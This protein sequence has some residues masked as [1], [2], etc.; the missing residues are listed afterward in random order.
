MVWFEKNI[1]NLKN[2][3]QKLGVRENF[4]NWK[5]DIKCWISGKI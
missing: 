2:G 3:I 5:N 1:L 4:L